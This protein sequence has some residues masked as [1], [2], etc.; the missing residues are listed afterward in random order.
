MLYTGVTGKVSIK[1]GEATAK[2]LAHISN[3]TVDISREMVEVASLG[4][5]YKEKVPGIMD[6]SAS[7]DGTADFATTSGQKDL[8][9]AFDAGTELECSFYL[10]AD[11][12]LVGTA[13]VESLSISTEAEGKADISISLAG[14]GG[15]L[16]TLPTGGN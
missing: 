2:D 3:F 6:W 1:Q 8:F 12:F 14:T 7:A 5:K 13:F 11:L 4:S 10:T 9:D 15:I 16:L